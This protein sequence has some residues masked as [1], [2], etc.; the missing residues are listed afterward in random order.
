MTLAPVVGL[1]QVGGQA[2]TDRYTYVPLVGVLVATVW[3]AADLAARARAPRLALPVALGAVLV[4]LRRPRARR[5]AARR[6]RM[7]RARARAPAA[8]SRGAPVRRAERMGGAGSARRRSQALDE[9]R[10]GPRRGDAGR[11]AAP[12]AAAGSLRLARAYADAAPFF[13]S[14]SSL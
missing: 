4:L 2:M 12:R 6:D 11:R 9:L 7:L 3:G 5:R 13:R 8:G 14:R 10:A 1:V